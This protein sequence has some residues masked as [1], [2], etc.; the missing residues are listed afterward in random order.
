MLRELTLPADGPAEALAEV[1]RRRGLRYSRAH[2]RAAVGRHRGR[3]HA[4]GLPAL[5]FDG[6]RCEASMAHVEAWCARPEP[7]A[8]LAP[9]KDSRQPE[10]TE[11]EGTEAP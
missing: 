8:V 3:A 7:L 10:D 2:V 6:R 1:V 4:Q 5:F 9:P 11:T